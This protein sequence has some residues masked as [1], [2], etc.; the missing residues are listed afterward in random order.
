MDL[1]DWLCDA[2][3][4]GK[5]LENVLKKCEEGGIDEVED[6]RELA[7]DMAS[8]DILFKG[9]LR[10]KIL[11]ALERGGDG[12]DGAPLTTT[13]AQSKS[14][15]SLDAPIPAGTKMLLPTGLR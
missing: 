15:K 4:S 1:S 8:F 3:F 7:S 2:G 6:L 5:K 14:K 13:D 9:L 11:K 10:S 12:H